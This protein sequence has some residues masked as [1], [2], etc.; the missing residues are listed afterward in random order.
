MSLSLHCY[1]CS[2]K[3]LSDAAV[4]SHCEAKSH[5]RA[6]ECKMCNGFIY[7]T[8]EDVQA[9]SG[10]RHQQVTPSEINCDI[11]HKKFASLAGLDQHV[12]VVHFLNCIVCLK[13]FD[14]FTA[15]NSHILAAHNFSCSGRDLTID[16]ENLLLGST[17]SH[18]HH[19]VTENVS[20][21]EVN[22]VYIFDSIQLPVE[23][24]G[25][26]YT[27]RQKN[28]YSG[29]NQYSA[30]QKN[31]LNGTGFKSVAEKLNHNT[32]GSASRLRALLNRQNIS[33]QYC[34]YGSCKEAFDNVQSLS[35]HMAEVH[36]INCYHCALTFSDIQELTSHVESNHRIH[37]TWCSA[38][39]A[40]EMDQL[41]HN[42]AEH[43]YQCPLCS[44]AFSSA[45]ALVLHHD[46]DHLRRGA[47][48]QV[49]SNAHQTEKQSGLV[50]KC[51]MCTDSFQ[52]TCSLLDHSRS[53]HPLHLE[54]PRCPQLFNN[55]ES[56]LHHYHAVHTHVCRVCNERFEDQNSL[57]VHELGS[58][59]QAAPITPQA[60][61][62]K[63]NDSG[64]YSGGRPQTPI[65][66]PVRRLLP[67]RWVCE[68]CEDVFASKEELDTHMLQSPLHGEVEKA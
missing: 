60:S 23:I 22:D 41:D 20:Q 24:W 51:D 62:T 50:L 38:V 9:H 30:M 3:F 46:N 53:A 67:V 48:C 26:E 35:M 16:S 45:K 15:L 33:I 29:G 19:P 31:V 2:I 17:R 34:Q 5:T 54:C 12:K 43:G 59:F 21:S 10:Q 57:Q 39:L 65:R 11:C 7:A 4:V 32:C 36:A 40:T 66:R 49:Q 63:S 47:F 37:C 18:E 42:S 61:P 27:H 14:D 55:E 1:T 44:A 68:F 28:S 64:F 13:G 56:I 52:D 58:H 8:A 6:F 25:E